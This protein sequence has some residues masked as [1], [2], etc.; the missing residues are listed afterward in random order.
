MVASVVAHFRVFDVQLDV[1]ARAL[2]R[3][4]VQ[5]AINLDSCQ[6]RVL[7]V[8]WSAV[9]NNIFLRFNFLLQTLRS[10]D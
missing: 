3:W 6:K 5:L 8:E 4:P 2:G 7:G 1:H 10:F 9:R